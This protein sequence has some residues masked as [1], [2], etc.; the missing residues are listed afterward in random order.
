M[1]RLHRLVT[2]LG[3]GVLLAGILVAF[4]AVDTAQVILEKCRP[5]KVPGPRT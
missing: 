2:D 4:I 5:G 3:F 1:N